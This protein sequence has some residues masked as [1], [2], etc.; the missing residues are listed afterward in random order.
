VQLAGDPIAGP[1]ELYAALA[2]RAGASAEILLV[3]GGA[4]LRKD[5]TLGSRP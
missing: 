3:R 2:D 1:S 4:E 5:V